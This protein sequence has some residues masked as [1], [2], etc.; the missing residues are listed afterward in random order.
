MGCK[1]QQDTFSANV[2]FWVVCWRAVKIHIVVFIRPALLL[3]NFKNTYSLV[4]IRVAIPLGLVVNWKLWNQYCMLLATACPFAIP[5]R[6]KWQ[7]NVP[8]WTLQLADSSS[9][10]ANADLYTIVVRIVSLCL[11]WYSVG[12]CVQCGNWQDLMSFVLWMFCNTSSRGLSVMS[13]VLRTAQSKTTLNKTG[14]KAC[15]MQGWL[16]SR[17]SGWFGG[18]RAV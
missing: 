15:G 11:W 7:K 9:V 10:C 18:R 17:G 8:K 1:R 3:K 16:G 5:I 4:F 12:V 2:S 13:A 14:A 6:F